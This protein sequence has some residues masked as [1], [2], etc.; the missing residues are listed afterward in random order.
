MKNKQID[1]YEILNNMITRSNDEKEIEESIKILES[2]L[3]INT[4]LFVVNTTTNFWR[5]SLS[6]WTPKT[7]VIGWYLKVYSSQK[8]SWEIEVLDLEENKTNGFCRYLGCFNYLDWKEFKKDIIWC[9]VTCNFEPARHGRHLFLS[10]GPKE[11]NELLELLNKKASEY[12]LRQE[13]SKKLSETFS[14]FLKLKSGL[15]WKILLKDSFKL[16]EAPKLGYKLEDYNDDGIELFKI[17]NNYIKGLLNWSS[18]GELDKIVLGDLESL[19]KEKEEYIIFL[20]RQLEHHI[21]KEVK[22]EDIKEWNKYYTID[23]HWHDIESV[24]VDKKL[25]W[26]NY[27]TKDG[28]SVFIKDRKKILFTLIKKTGE[29]EANKIM[30]QIYINDLFIEKI[31]GINKVVTR[32]DSWNMKQVSEL[33]DLNLNNLKQMIPHLSN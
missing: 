25:G 2:L 13:N 9:N 12:N 28:W 7:F 11:N 5:D 21:L 24:L 33:D 16:T 23:Y 14:Y 29:K 4:K 1:S 27:Y 15:D 3:P 17:V 30:S 31:E 10:M 32:K 22:E 18:Y 6:I 26:W 19:K 8:N 20:K